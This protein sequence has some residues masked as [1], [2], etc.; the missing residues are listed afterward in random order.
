MANPTNPNYGPGPGQRFSETMRHYHP[1]DWIN[2]VLA[3]WLFISPWT[4]AFAQ[5]M[6][7]LTP[8]ATA[9]PAAGPEYAAWNAWILGVVVFLIA[10]SAALRPEYWQGAWQE[11]VNVILGIWI[12][13]APWVLGFSDVT[14]AAWNHWIVGFLI[15]AVS[16][17]AMQGIRR[18]TV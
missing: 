1:Q 7:T 14:W 13:I 17:S 11:W 2:V 5:P 6:D 16:L 8:G 3:I 9:L 10:L 18:T 4:L 15:F 12:F